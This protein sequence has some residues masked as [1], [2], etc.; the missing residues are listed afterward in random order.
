MHKNL[1][2]NTSLLTDNHNFFD[3]NNKKKWPDVRLIFQ[4]GL[5]QKINKTWKTYQGRGEKAA[6]EVKTFQMQL[7]FLRVLCTSVFTDLNII[8]FN[9]SS[10]RKNWK[11]WSL[12][13]LFAFSGYI[14]HKVSE[15]NV[16]LSFFSLQHTDQTSEYRFQT[17]SWWLVAPGRSV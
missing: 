8:L 1:T 15:V 12:L 4:S 3:Q 6:N 10:G 16:A 9:W 14:Y 5:M 2:I 11:T 17:T 13:F 7:V